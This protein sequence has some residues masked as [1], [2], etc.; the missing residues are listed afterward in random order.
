MPR[1]SSFLGTSGTITHNTEHSVKS[2]SISY[3]AGCHKKKTTYVAAKLALCAASL[4]ADR[5]H[6][7]KSH[8]E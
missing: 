4:K 1:Y 3:L 6:K 2:K 5:R 8:G 7:Q